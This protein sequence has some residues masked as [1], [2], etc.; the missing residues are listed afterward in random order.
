[1]NNIND[2]KKRDKKAFA[3]L[4]N[5][6]KLPVY[7]LALRWTKSKLDAEDILQKTFLNAYL[8]ISLFREQSSIKTWLF[9]IAINLLNNHSRFFKNKKMDDIMDYSIPTKDV[10]PLQES[11]I[12]EENKNILEKINKLKGKQRSIL[13]LRLYEDLSFSEIADIVKCT[14]NSAKVNYHYAIE[15]LRQLLEKEGMLNAMPK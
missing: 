10:S 7:Y 8:G 12:K 4:F 14:E 9:Q 1:M 6:Y 11:E 13:L 3:E 15:K 2:L 5:E